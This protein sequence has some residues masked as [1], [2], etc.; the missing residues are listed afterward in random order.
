M[1]GL[2]FNMDLFTSLVLSDDND[3]YRKRYRD[4]IVGNPKDTILQIAISVSVGLIAFLAFCVS[5]DAIY[6]AAART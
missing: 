3:N 1:V 5:L 4:Q 2:L 6:S